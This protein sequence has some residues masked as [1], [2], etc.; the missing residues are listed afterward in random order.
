VR[1]DS[2]ADE[3]DATL[4]AVGRRLA[5][6]RQARHL[7]QE[8][9]ADALD[10]GTKYYQ[11][12][13][14]GTQN[15]TLGTMV[16]IAR[17]LDVAV[18]SLLDAPRDLAVRSGRPRKDRARPTL[19]AL[20]PLRIAGEPAPNNVPLMSLEAAA[21][22]AGRASEAQIAGWVALSDRRRPRPGMFVA[23]IVGRS[24]APQ[25][26]DGAYAL[27]EGPAQA[28]GEG[29]VLLVEHRDWLD[30]DT[31]G[32]Y[33]VKRVYFVER[34]EGRRKRRFVRFVSVNRDYPP[35]ELELDEGDE[36]LRVIAR[37]VGVLSG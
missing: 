8:Q 5:E 25:I 4:L 13:E 33:T 31:R 3:V 26:P 2:E 16:R 32:R 29:E 12:I 11:R 6:L 34:R 7:T 28:S 35:V 37:F 24:M 30:P 10:V 27:F 19:G 23:K 9:V 36:N 17:V 15:L 22:T 21:G 18:D 14:G 20:A 1:P